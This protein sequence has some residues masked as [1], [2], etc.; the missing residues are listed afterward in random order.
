MENKFEVCVKVEV[1]DGRSH[2][3]VEV[4]PSQDLNLE[5]VGKV[6]AGGLALAIKSSE[7]EAEYMKEIMEYLQN[8]FVN[9]DSFS[10]FKRFI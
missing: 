10:D 7:K 8:E 6:L 9:I 1:K 4:P 2:I 3:S 5:E